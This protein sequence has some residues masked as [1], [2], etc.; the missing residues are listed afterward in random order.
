VRSGGSSLL[1][2]K[3]SQIR[4]YDVVVVTGKTATGA[5]AQAMPELVRKL[6]CIRDD[7]VSEGHMSALARYPQ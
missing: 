3:P 2:S 4:C 5:E 6:D 7:S 1:I